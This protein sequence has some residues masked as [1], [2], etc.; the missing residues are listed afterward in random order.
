MTTPVT[1]SPK[2]LRINTPSK[3][4]GSPSEAQRWLDSV[5][6]YLYL[7]REIYDSDEK[8]VIFALSFMTENSAKVWS[9]TF[10]QTALGRNPVS[11]GTTEN[12]NAEFKTSFIHEDT[13]SNAITWLT[14]TKVSKELPLN[15][16]IS[17]FQNKVAISEI[18]D[19]GV[20]INYFAVG[21]NPSLM[22]RI[23]SMDTVPT[24]IEGWYTKA[25][26]FKNQWERADVLDTRRKTFNSPH[27][28]TYTPH[29]PTQAPRDPN[30]MDVDAIRLEKLTDNERQRCMREG[31][32]LR[33]RQP[34]HFANKCRTN[35]RPNN[36]VQ[37]AR[38]EE[39]PEEM[40]V[41]V[42]AINTDF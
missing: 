32:C 18:T 36:N 39:L 15:E 21:I 24:T 16:Y 12:F 6:I 19:Q 4:D 8:Q 20:L 31:L 33:C 42:A 2:E 29:R 26:H 7:N 23:M 10:I 41:T 14:A 38:I 37:V 13:K 9:S 34:G 25:I 40:D 1:H 22:R 30:A 11:F 17:S 27:Q 28:K 5:R 35:I 3:F